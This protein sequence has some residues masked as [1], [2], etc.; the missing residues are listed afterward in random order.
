MST[1]TQA[2]PTGTWNVDPTHSNVEF[3]VDYLVGTFRGTFTPFGVTLTVDENGEARLTGSALAEHVQVKDQNLETHLQSPDFFDTERAP[4]LRFE[5]TS[6]R[7]EGDGV[8]V[9]GTLTIRGESRPVKLTGTFSDAIEDYLGQQ[10]IGL[11][12]DTTVDRTDFG[13]NWNLPLP[14]GKQALGNEVRIHTELYFVKTD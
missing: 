9:E 10:R 13:I 2:L 6:I 3:A 5:S 8:T 14:S 11:V 1:V 12:L 4:E 7:L